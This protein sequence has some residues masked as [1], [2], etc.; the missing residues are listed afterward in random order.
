MINVLGLALYGPLAASTRYRL[1][2]YCP[3]LAARDI[4]LDVY[5]LLDDK[6]LSRKFAGGRL[7]LISMLRSGFCRVGNLLAQ[8]KYD[9]AIIH[10]EL[11][12]LL[13]GGVE[14]RLLRIPYIYDFDDAFY[15]KYKS[16]RFRALPSLLHD[17]FDTV[18]R[19][20][21]AVTA[22]SKVLA[23]YAESLN[24][25]TTLLPTVVDTAHYQHEPK[26]DREL[27]TVG[28]IGSPSTSIYI[29]QLVEPLSHLGKESPVRLIIIGGKTLSIPNVD[30]VEMPWHEDSEISYINTFDVG[31]MPLP[32][33]D[34][35]RGKC[36]FKII[37]Y[38]ACGVPVIASPVGANLD[39]LN[40]SC[41]SF[42]NGSEQWLQALRYMRDNPEK[43]EA[44]GRFGRERIESDFSLQRNL[45]LMIS[46][47]KSI[48]E[49]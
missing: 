4:H 29:K 33:D 24:S 14:S 21:T 1:L 5:S 10:C 27:F 38:M 3:G 31:V 42:A 41:G 49:I 25:S 13:P 48:C 8:R 28:W 15:M 32:D 44:M 18:I 37:Q 6:Y 46:I 40:K 17:K 12:P 45:P 47:I 9:C 36:A 16:N 43:R 11:F 2:Q 19:C 20:A 34:W 26:K 39:V 35:S 23:K 22:G 7:P 30:V